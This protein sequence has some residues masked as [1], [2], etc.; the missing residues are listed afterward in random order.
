MW[1][2]SRKY[3]LLNKQKD[4]SIFVNNITNTINF[5]IFEIIDCD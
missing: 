2:K 5:T 1:A 3:K 4:L